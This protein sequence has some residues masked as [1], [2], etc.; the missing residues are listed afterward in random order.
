MKK[1]ISIESAIIILL[2]LIVIAFAV[3]KVGKGPGANDQ[4]G[5]TNTTGTPGGSGLPQHGKLVTGP[6]GE[7]FSGT[8]TAYDTSCFSDG[9]CSVSV[10]GKKVIVV[11]GGRRLEP[12]E[13][14]GRLLGVDSIGDLEQHIGAHAN[15]YATTTPEGDYTIY[16]NE[17]FYVEVVGVKGNNRE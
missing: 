6:E 1:Y 2:I 14:V 3:L 7:A 16:G 12:N 15:V 11:R 8:I 5:Q 9:I 4:N 17:K 13:T 10:D